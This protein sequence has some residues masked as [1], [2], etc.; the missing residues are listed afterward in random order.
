M[1]SFTRE[2]SLIARRYLQPESEHDF[3]LPESESDDECLVVDSPSEEMSAEMTSLS[4]EG[5]I[6]L[7]KLKVQIAYLDQVTNV[8]ADAVNQRSV[9]IPIQTLTP[10]SVTLA[11]PILAVVQ[12]EDGVF[13][14]SFVDAN[15]NASGDT[16][17]EAVE[18]LK[19]V[20]TQ[21]YR[22]LAK[23]EAALGSEPARQLTVLREFIAR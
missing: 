2:A 1:I 6:E 3:L 11:S 23:N 22:I 20:I 12:P 9:I 13:V 21:T 5:A 10:R 18:M 8:L 4:P 19:D 17:Q 16:Q 7:F 15:L 14:A